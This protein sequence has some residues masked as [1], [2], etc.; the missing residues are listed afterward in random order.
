MRI[1]ISKKIL[2]F[3]LSIVFIFHYF[4]KSDSAFAQNYTIDNAYLDTNSWVTTNYTDTDTDQY[5]E[6]FSFDL[7]IDL[8]ISDNVYI[9]YIENKTENGKRRCCYKRQIEILFC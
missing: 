9:K 7:V 6:T 3:F 5:Y 2:L 4:Y 8:T 1:S